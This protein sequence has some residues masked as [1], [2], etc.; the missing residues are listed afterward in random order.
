MKK[1]GLLLAVAILT[2]NMAVF[3][4]GAQDAGGS[5]K[6]YRIAV[7][8]KLTS[9]SWFQRM[10]VGV[11][12]YAK[13]TGIDAF[14]TGPSEGD[15]ALQAR[16]IEDLI[17]QGVDAICVVPFSTQALEPVLK[18][19]RDQGIVVIS[20]EASGMTNIDYDIEAFDNDAYGRH[21]ME[22]LGELTGGKGDYIFEVGSLTSESHNQWVDA[23]KALQL[24][25]FPGMKQYGDKIETADNLQ[26]S[27]NKVKEVLTANPNLKGIQ[28]SAMPDVAGAALA[29]EELGLAGKVHIVG[30][31]LVSVSGK[32]IK[33]GTIAMASFWDPALAGK[34]M[35]QLAL[36]VLEKEKISDGMNLNVPGYTNLSLKGKVLSGQAWIDITKSNVDDP[37][38]NF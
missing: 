16:F 22:K 12:D 3:A 20:H 18:K 36:K 23:A 25:K 4:T 35:I 33:D 32:Y 38:I 2:V 8:P 11:K 26:T 6:K 15:G 34:A 24:K 5:G 27:Y 13:E 21:F 7:V 17:S 9:I 30:T 37:S 31:S 10:E 19:A 1:M 29:V 28:G 14:Y